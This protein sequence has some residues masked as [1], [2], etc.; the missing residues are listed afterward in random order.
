[1]EPG[2]CRIVGHHACSLAASDA[3]V[4]DGS[5]AFSYFTAASVADGLGGSYPTSV[6]VARVR[7]SNDGM[8]L[9]RHDSPALDFPWQPG[10]RK[11]GMFLGDYHSLLVVA[12]RVP[13]GRA[14]VRTLLADC[15]RV[16]LRQP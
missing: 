9:E 6:R 1:M 7:L 3:V 16:R 15:A 10:P 11:Q 4:A 5:L 8:V 12:T 14:V 13:A 2:S